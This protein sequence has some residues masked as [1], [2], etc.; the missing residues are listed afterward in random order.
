VLV[1]LAEDVV[2]LVDKVVLALEDIAVDVVEDDGI[3]PNHTRS[4]SVRTGT[5]WPTSIAEKPIN[6]VPSP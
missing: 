4:S 5:E 2:V 6:L 1:E 3:S